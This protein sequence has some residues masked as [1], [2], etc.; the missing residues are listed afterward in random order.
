MI[1]N[2]VNFALAVITVVV[3]SVDLANDHNEY[4]GICNY[5]PSYDY[6]YGTPSPEESGRQ[7]ICLSYKNEVMIIFFFFRWLKNYKYC[8]LNLL[9]NS[10]FKE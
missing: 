3:Y 1:L 6:G 7:E 5:F 8:I 2:G 4:R 9:P 10:Q